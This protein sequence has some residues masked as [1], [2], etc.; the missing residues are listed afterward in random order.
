CGSGALHGQVVLVLNLRLTTAQLRPREGRRRRG[1]TLARSAASSLSERTLLRIQ[2]S[3]PGSLR[4]RA[5]STTSGTRA[6]GG[7]RRVRART[8]RAGTTEHASK[9]FASVLHSERLVAQQK[10]NG[11]TRE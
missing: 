6:T 11:R 1:S 3:G 5:A 4:G 2:G 8:L 10:Q 7:T 9:A